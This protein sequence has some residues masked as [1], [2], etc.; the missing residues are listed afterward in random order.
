[1][2]EAWMELMFLGHTFSRK[3]HG[4]ESVKPVVHFFTDPFLRKCGNFV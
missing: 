2:D 4:E 3:G 1:M